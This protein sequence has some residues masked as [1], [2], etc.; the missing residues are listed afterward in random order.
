VTTRRET[1]KTLS[2]A[3]AA[4][5]AGPLAVRGAHAADRFT[6][7]AHAVHKAAATTGAGGD[8][9]APWRAQHNVDIE[10]LTFGVEAVNERAFK[11]ASLAE[12]SVDLV[13]ILDRYTGPQF[14][15]LFEDLRTWQAKDA[16]PDF[17]EIPAGMVAAHSFGGKIT[18]IPFRHATHGLHYNTEYFAERGVT[19]APKTVTDAIALAEKLTYK[20]ADGLQVYGLVMNFDDPATP[21][22][23]IRGFGGDFI[24]PDYKVVV[25]S[26]AS[27]RGVAVLCDLY[28]KGVLPEE[29]D[30]P[31]D[32]GRHDVHAA[33]A[34][35]DDQQ[36]VQP[37]HQLQRSQGVEVPGQDRGVGAAAR[38]RRQA[39][40]RED[41]GVGD[42]DPAQCARQ[43]ALVE[44]GQAPVDA[45]ERDRRDAQ[46]QRAGAAVRLRGRA[47]QGADPVRRR[48]E[49]GARQR[50]P[51]RARIPERRQV[52]GHLHRGARQRDARQQGARRG[53]GRGQEAR[54]AAAADVTAARGPR[55]GDLRAVRWFH[56][57]MT[58]PALGLLLAFLVLPAAYVAWL[59]TTA[60]TYG[61]PARFVGLANY[62]QLAGDPIFWRAFWNTFFVVNGIVYAELLLGLGLAVLLTGPMPFKAAIVAVLLAPYAITESSGIVMWR[63]ML[64]PDVGLVS[65][66]MEGAG[67]PALAWST[68]PAATLFLASTIA[69]WHHLPFTFL[70]LYA[71]LTTVPQ[72]V[73]EAAEIDG[74][75]RWQAFRLVTIR[76]IMPAVLI[77]VLF[78][79]IFAIRTFA[80]VWL[81]TEG[82]PARLSEV[83]AIYL[84]RETF[85]Y[86]EFGMASA[87]GFVM[88]A[89]SLVIALPYLKR[90][91]AEAVRGS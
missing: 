9:T 34:R 16:I 85:K 78:R 40:A 45:R 77:A 11:E 41:V 91:Y 46:R 67:L 33:G 29:L 2:G 8:V 26:P 23:W 7:I 89:M 61:Q 36:P 55:A 83:L 31:Q 39:D 50:A 74:A 87:T 38:R 60:T 88:L 15:G 25:D 14:A 48:R 76:L 66:W 53:D 20:R 21:I 10:W 73:L 82:G 44:P 18:A 19:G 80:E 47:R 4:L 22:D 6:I 43:G 3:L 24:S 28:K 79:Y 27:V 58:G 70:I 12:G 57:A 75:S 30:E 86:H 90:M 17:G 63:Y 54:H 13:F 72:D 62:A 52:D 42:G 59:S 68:N 69:V 84:Y 49:G 5:A 32:R 65:Q 1:L 35:R 56:Y 71:A 37:L 51:G 81:L 64:E